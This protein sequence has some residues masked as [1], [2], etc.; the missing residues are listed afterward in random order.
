MFRTLRF[1][2]LPLL[3]LA[4]VRAPAQTDASPTPTPLPVP[5]PPQRP[6][7]NAAELYVVALD[8]RGRFTDEEKQIFT[9]QHPDP[10]AKK[11]A[12]LFGKTQPIVDLLRRARKA[13][14]ADWGPPPHSIS[15]QSMAD[16]VGGTQAIA[17]I[18]SWEAGYRF[19]TDAPGAVNDIASL[20]AMSRSEVGDLV[21]LMSNTGIHAIGLRVLARNA[22]RI[23]PASDAD[24]AYITGKAAAAEGLRRGANGEAEVLQ[25]LLDE[26]S[27]PTSR[28]WSEIKKMAGALHIDPVAAAAQIQWLQA[29]ERELATKGLAPEP[30]FQHWWTGKKAEAAAMP[31]V[32]RSMASIDN[33]C[34][35]VRG[36][37]MQDA[38]LQAGL[39]LQR[40]DKAKFDSIPDP[41]SGKPFGYSETPTGYQLTSTFQHNGKNAN[42]TFPVPPEKN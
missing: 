21:S 22:N 38:M 35:M 25:S 17:W 39:A 32:A 13:D 26:F 2:I 36:S 28:N 34:A 14:Y 31:A 41:L 6:G 24:I 11:A 29:T 37:L 15:D 23:T 42:M 4:A 19:V 1:L 16:R 33:V 40:H 8:F 10:V 5:T 3:L 7:L 9:E 18:V 20:I 12:A 27:S 30:E